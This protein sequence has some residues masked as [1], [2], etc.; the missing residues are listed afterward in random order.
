M[1]RMNRKSQVGKA[2]DGHWS[3]HAGRTGAGGRAWT[4]GW[5]IAVCWVLC[6]ALRPVLADQTLEQRR[7]RIEALSPAEK[8][9][10]LERFKRF[11]RLDPAEQERLRRLRKQLD[12]DEQGEQLRQVMQRYYDWLK[13]LAPYRRAEL[14]E[15]PADARVKRIQELLADA[16]RR[17]GRP[18]GSWGETMHRAWRGG[19]LP[20]SAK[21]PLR[22]PDPA[23]MEGLFAWM[24]SYAK[25]H[26]DALLKKLPNPQ[27]E[28]LRNELARVTDPVRRQELLGWI[29][30]WWQLDSPSQLPALSDRELAE[31]RSKLSET[32]RKRLEGLAPAEQWRAI[33]GLITAFLLH[34]YSSR[35]TGKPLPAVTEEELAQFFER[36]LTAEQRDKLLNLSG[37]EMQR[38]LWRMYVNWKI[39]Q[40]P[41]RVGR[42]KR[43]AAPPSSSGEGPASE[44]PRTTPG[45]PTTR[46]TKPRA[47]ASAKSSAGPSSGS[48]PTRSR[49]PSPKPAQLQ[50]PSNQPEPT[51][52]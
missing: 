39:R 50:P 28:R 42:E 15:L 1:R 20:D 29:W 44:S 9:E 13:T 24:D 5:C 43:G 34:Q 51:R 27:R 12:E 33:S 25:R 35:H 38:Q 31:L 46:P 10:L 30:L 26:E 6:G 49:P 17:S 8:Q 18:T 37:E 4:V 36:E 52:P 40:L 2:R 7:A 14:L 22:R 47:P 21:R 45:S 41:F 3:A 48:D 19:A 23:D 32:T 11:N 16:S